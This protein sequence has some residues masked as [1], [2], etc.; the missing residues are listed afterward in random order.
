MMGDAIITMAFVY[1]MSFY[2]YGPRALVLL[3]VSAATSCLCDVLATLIGKRKPSRRDLSPVVTGM[4][5]PLLMPASI[6]YFVVAVAAAFGILVAKHPFGGTGHNVFNPAAAGY[7][8][9]AICFTESM[10]LYPQPREWLPVLGKIGEMAEITLSNGSAFTLQLGGVPQYDLIEMVLGNYPGPMG[11]TNILV[12][13]AC[14][15]YL[16]FRNT[17]RWEIPVFFYSTAAVTAFLIRLGGLGRG[18]GWRTAWDALPY[19]LTSGVFLLA[20]VFM[21]GD[22]VTAPKRD[23]S[24]IAYAVTAGVLVI[25]FRQFGGMEEGTPFAIL[26]MNA[27]VWGFDMLGERVA[28]LI[29]RRR[30]PA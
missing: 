24:K 10:F 8:F 18:E 9:A 30:K 11:A 5:L 1:A 28:S 13:L 15:L 23:W 20:G 6:D 14:L 19:E 3:A 4:L 21:L 17:V 27:S 26:L 7:S 29:R 16:M 22:P 2:Y 12:V 25:L